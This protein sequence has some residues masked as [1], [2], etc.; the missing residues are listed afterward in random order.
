MLQRSLQE[1]FSFDARSFSIGF[2][3]HVFGDFVGFFN[4]ALGNHRRGLLCAQHVGECK[5]DILY[6][7]LWSL[8]ADMDAYFAHANNIVASTLPRCEWNRSGVVRFHRVVVET[9]Q[10]SSGFVVQAGQGVCCR[11]VCQLLARKPTVGLPARQTVHRERS[12][13]R[14][15]A[16]R[17]SVLLDVQ[18]VD[19]TLV[20]CRSASQ[21]RRHSDQQRSATRQIRSVASRR[22]NQC[23]AA[24]RSTLHSRIL[25]AVKMKTKTKKTQTNKYQSDE[26]FQIAVSQKTLWSFQ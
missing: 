14:C 7:P 1:S 11:A 12:D 4:K 20:V 5:S 6:L 13:A 16:Q 9:L 15:A 21:L 18:R 23:V 3:G 24:R 19:A 10:F 2:A 25:F 8:M 22:S 17:N 26:H